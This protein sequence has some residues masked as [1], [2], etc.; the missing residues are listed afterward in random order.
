MTEKQVNDSKSIPRVG[1]RDRLIVQL[2]ARYRLGTNK[3]FHKLE[4]PGRKI[5]AVIKV[6]GR[7]C[8]MGLLQKFSLYHPKCY[9]TL[10]PQAAQPL[11][12]S[13]HRIQSLGPQTLPIEYGALAYATLGAHCHRRLLPRELAECCPWL[14][15]KLL[16]APHCLNES[17]SSPVLELIRVDLGGKPD[18]VARKCAADIRVRAARN[19]FKKFVSGGRFRLVIV[20]ATRDK[21]TAIRQALDDHLW[22]TGMQFHLAVVS[23]LLLLTARINHGA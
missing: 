16:D 23:D 18:H 20:T 10:G 13:D 5:N 6:T 21:A 15:P 1:Q 19:E 8:R 17:G 3:V 12:L 11:G 4:F 14:Q 7:L 22:P 9:F 2:V